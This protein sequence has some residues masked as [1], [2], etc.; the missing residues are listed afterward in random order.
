MVRLAFLV[1]KPTQFEVPFFRAHAQ[2]VQNGL[3]KVCIDVYYLKH[4][5]VKTLFDDEIGRP[6]GW[7]FDDQ[8]G[9]RFFK[10]PS[11][12]LERAK[13]LWKDIF[14]ADYDAVIINGYRHNDFLLNLFIDKIKR[15]PLVLRGDSVRVYRRKG[16]KQAVKSLMLRILYLFPDAFL[17]VGSLSRQALIHY[18]V[19]KDHIFLFPYAIDNDQFHQKSCLT[20]QQRSEA[21]Q[22]MGIPETSVVFIAVTKFVPR[23]GPMD[24]LQAFHHL[25]PKAP[26]AMLLL[27][28]DGPQ[29]EEVK[30]YLRQNNLKN[31]FWVGYQP[32]SQLPRLYGISDAFIHPAHEECWGVSVNEAMA[33]GLPIILSHQVGSGADLLDGNGL[34]YQ[35]GNFKEL[36]DCIM[37]L[38]EEEKLRLRMGKR[39]LEIIERWGFRH[40]SNQLQALVDFLQQSNLTLAK[41]TF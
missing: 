26:N 15:I 7:D 20:S 6:P 37:T 18:G 12:K 13:F 4:S 30:E 31:V 28:G 10:I 16:I 19:P 17:A 35:S 3:T 36:S 14:S 11:G 22:G 5:S 33:C 2:L 39:S 24:L 38:T 40:T 9:Y 32:Y 21:R 29:R 34:V 27:V 25:D 41:K 1:E 23:E 8:E